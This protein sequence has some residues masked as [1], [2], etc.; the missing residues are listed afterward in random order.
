VLAV[1]SQ[2][3]I[4]CLRSVISRAEPTVPMTFP[5]SLTKGAFLT[6]ST[7]GLPRMRPLSSKMQG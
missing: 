6:S 2:L 5:S 4:R 3:R 1:Q 7:T